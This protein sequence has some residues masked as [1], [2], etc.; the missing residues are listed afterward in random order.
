MIPCL[1]GADA[2]RWLDRLF[3]K[4]W[5]AVSSGD[6]VEKTVRDI[7]G[8][9]REQGDAALRNLAVRFGETPPASF[10]LL[11]SDVQAAC[12]RVSDHTKQLLQRAAQRIRT[13]A[14]GV[15]QL[16]QPF[17]WD[18]AAI[19][20]GMHWAPAQRVACY[21]PGGRFPLPST[22]LMTAVTAQVAGVPD[23]SLICPAPC[24]EVIY[25][26]TLAGVNR[27]YRM[28][29]AQAVAAACFGTE[30]VT[31]VDMLV[32][33]GN[34]YVTEAKKQLMGIMGIDMLAGPSE[35]AILADEGVNPD[36]AA[37]DLL[38]Q[39]EHDPDA[40]AVV[41]TPSI[42][43]ANA[44]HQS[45]MAMIQA[46]PALPAYLKEKDDWG[47]ILVLESEEA[48]IQA[49]N[50]LAPE[51]V[52]LLVQNPHALKPKLQHYGTLFMGYHTPV[53][54][55]DYVAGPNHT[56]PTARTARFSGGLNPLTFLR[57]QSWVHATS[58]AQVIAQDSR[59][60]AE[61]EGLIAHA[62]S[63]AV[64]EEVK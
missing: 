21:V 42:S 46:H 4:D 8:Q 10:K 19:Q 55:G 2:A 11:D 61:I 24:D 50:H 58:Q 36:W 57:P 14:A 5:A 62:A 38:A 49:I 64:R 16:V 53:P 63:A 7:I 51:H 33:P 52:E 37:L 15:M 1:Q 29:G 48:C 28:G 12:D 41:L 13:F 43:V 30:S 47:A 59:S 39:A 60:M 34:A 54:Y 35:V 40:R 27:F 3:S 17:T 25:A 31:P 9:V 23:I 56:L 20:T 45:L 6:G 32:G 18:E 26:G 44:I 22:A